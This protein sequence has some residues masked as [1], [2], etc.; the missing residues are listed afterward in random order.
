MYKITDISI[1]KQIQNDFKTY[2][3]LEIYITYKGYTRHTLDY[4]ITYDSKTID[5]I[6]HADIINIFEKN[7]QNLCKGKLADSQIDKLLHGVIDNI[8]SN[9]KPIAKSLSNSISF[10]LL[11]SQAVIQEVSLKSSNML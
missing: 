4:Y 11:H 10:A 9:S 3:A 7:Y 1:K 6:N 2:L 8:D 5:T